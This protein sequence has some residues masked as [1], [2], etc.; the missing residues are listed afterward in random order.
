MPTY[1]TV[2][3]VRGSAWN[4]AV[5][6]RD[7]A[8]W[9]EH[10]A[11]MNALA[12]EGLVVLVGPWA[13]ARRS[14]LSSTRPARTLSGPASPRIPGANPAYWRSIES[15]RG[16]SC[17]TVGLCESTR[18]SSLDLFAALGGSSCAGF[19]TCVGSVASSRGR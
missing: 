13:L 3:R 9:L 18:C 11:F 10:A 16:R 1:L 2:R 19:S 5:P 12:A 7:Q 8:F 6:M 17:S 14:S 4:P 15:S